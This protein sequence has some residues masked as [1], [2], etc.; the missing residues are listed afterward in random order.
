MKKLTLGIA[1]AIILIASV[2]AQFGYNTLRNGQGGGSTTVNV[3]VVGNITSVSNSDGCIFVSP[4][5]G[6]IVLTF[7]TTCASAGS[8]DITAVLGDAWITNGTTSGAVN[9]VFN[10]TLFNQT[11]AVVGSLYGFNTTYNVTYHA[12]IPFGY[13]MTIP[14]ISYADATFIPLSALPLINRT[15]PTWVNI[16]NIPAGFADGIDNEGTGNASFNESYTN[17][18]YASIIWGYNMSD[19]SF[20]ITYQNFAYNHTVASNTS[21]INGYGK[22]FYN[23]SDGTGTGNA[24]WN[25]TYADTL[26]AGIEWDYNETVATNASIVTTYSYIWYN[27]TITANTSI[28]GTYGKWFYNHSDGVGTG[29]ASFN[30]SHTNTLYAGIEWDYNQSAPVLTYVDATFILFSALPLA[31]RTSPTWA[32]ITNIPAGFADGVDDTGATISNASLNALFLN[33]S[34]T[35]ANQNINISPYNLTLGGLLRFAFQETIDNVIDGLVRVT[36]NLNVTGTFEAGAGTLTTLDTG[37]GANELYDMNQN[38]QTT[39]NVVFNRVN[40]TQNATFVQRACWGTA[41]NASIYY[42][43]AGLHIKVN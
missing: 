40:V 41:C 17:T 18:R 12:L 22:W 1:I 21:L 14:A 35:N 9:L 24:S 11:L 36:G 7:N 32:N 13:N 10:G 42:D 29:N 3:G 5:T 8:G 28:F 26:Y 39:D 19:G 43:N 33:L 20:N 15:S 30:Q 23:Q 25:Q 31:N 27:H 38:M 34:G 37:Q 2:S 16:T 4:T 6:D